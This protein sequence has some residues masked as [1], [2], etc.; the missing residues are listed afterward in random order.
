MTGVSDSPLD[1]MIIAA[2]LYDTKATY[3]HLLA[4]E[5]VV[6]IGMLN[7]GHPVANQTTVSVH[8]QLADEDVVDQIA[9]KVHQAWMAEKIAQ[10]YADHVMR[11]DCG[12]TS[13]NGEPYTATCMIP[14]EK[15]HPDM[16]LYQDLSESVK[17]YDRVT[18][19]AVLYAI[20]DYGKETAHAPQD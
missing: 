8:Y 17:E 3:E 4:T 13:I 6:N 11:W 2:F 5:E 7:V 20:R 12:L 16:L 18:V 1:H 14:V 15:H 10:G 9:D 19:R